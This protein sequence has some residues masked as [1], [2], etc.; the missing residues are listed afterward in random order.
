[1]TISA[2]T[3]ISL[4]IQKILRLANVFVERW[5]VTVLPEHVYHF[6]ILYVKNFYFQR[7][8]IDIFCRQNIDVEN[9][10]SVKQIL[11]SYSIV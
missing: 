2:D 7:K 8:R 9:K 1:M 6:A 5:L 4:Q 10:T 3:T 11:F